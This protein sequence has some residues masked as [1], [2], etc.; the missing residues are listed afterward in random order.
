MKGIFVIIDGVADEPCSVLG[1]KTPLEVANTPNLDALAEKSKIYSCHSVG[2]GIAPES[3]SAVMSLLGYESNVVSRGILET[4]GAGVKIKNGDLALRANFATIDNWHNK[5]IVDRRAGRTLTSWEA[6]QLAKAIN[7][8]RIHEKFR[9]EFIPT[10]GHRGVLIF[11]GGFSDN[12]S[13]VDPFYSEGKVAS[14]GDKLLQSKSFDDEDD[15]NLSAELINKF[16]K[17]CFDVLH[18]HPVNINRVKKG[19]YPA[20]IVLCRDAG[21]S[22]PR[23]KKV[24]GRWLALG[25]MP[26]EVGIAKVSGM[27][28]YRFRYPKL[29]GIDSY[30]HLYKGLNRAIKNAKRMLWWYKNKYDYFYIHFKETDVPGHNGNPKD[31]VRMIEM[32][33]KGFFRYIRKIIKDNKLIVCADHTTSCRQKMHTSH[34]VPVMVYNSQNSGKKRYS[35]SFVRGDE[36]MGKD[37]LKRFLYK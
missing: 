33:D 20:N 11:R 31:K 22:I 23:L 12:V 28:V 14:K 9:F 24:K 8:K 32:I 35:E 3:S 37:V 36:I 7:G 4:I 6:K 26:L 30:K 16:V 19:L 21:S 18:S 10:I 2:K 34:P 13:N 1:G 25:Y 5:R 17:H 29:R 15:S 27:E